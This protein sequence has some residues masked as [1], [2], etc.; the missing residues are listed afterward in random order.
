M[1]A[2][3]SVNITCILFERIFPACRC[4]EKYF[5]L[6]HVLIQTIKR[7]FWCRDDL[8]RAGQM[9]GFEAHRCNH[10]CSS[11]V[12]KRVLFPTVPDFQ[13][14]CESLVLHLELFVPHLRVIYLNMLDILFDF[15]T[16]F[17][18]VW[19]LNVNRNV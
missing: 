18:L 17:P 19:V 1:A 8:K 12:H 7:L 2:Y 3:G 4:Y 15:L 16:T 14:I 6:C 5:T 9:S 13:Y 11:Q 10:C